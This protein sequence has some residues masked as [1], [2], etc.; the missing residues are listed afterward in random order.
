L[1]K[2]IRLGAERWSAGESD[3]HESRPTGNRH[4]RM[5]A[6]RQMDQDRVWS[7]AGYPCSHV[8]VRRIDEDYASDVSRMRGREEPGVKAADRVSNEDVWGGHL[9]DLK[10]TIQFVDDLLSV[11]RRRS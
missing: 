10:Q 11:S 9:C 5:Q 6:H 1:G 3:V 2:L 4:R 8:F 7:R